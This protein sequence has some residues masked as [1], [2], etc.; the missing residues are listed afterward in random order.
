MLN[1]AETKIVCQT[2]Q[3]RLQWLQKQDTGSYTAEQQQQHQL[4]LTLLNNAYN[5]LKPRRASNAP[6]KPQRHPRADVFLDEIRALV[7]DDDADMATIISSG[8]AEIGIKHIKSVGSGA[9]A[10]TLI[11]AAPAPY[12]LI[13]CDWNMPENDGMQ[14]H[15]SMSKNPKYKNSF[16]MLVSGVSDAEQIKKAISDG[17]DDYIVKPL[18]EEIL[19]KKINR[20]FPAV[21]IGLEEE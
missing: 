17:V 1:S 21:K 15:T 14:V 2:L 18:D 3:Q 19:I 5:K 8:L 10:I 11:Y 13:M 9:E 7:I 16:F 12:H 20:A 6:S 4:A